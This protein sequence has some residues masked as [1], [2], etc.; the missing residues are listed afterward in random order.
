[1]PT[2]SA[3]ILETKSLRL[4]QH[5]VPVDFTIDGGTVNLFHG[6]SR[7][8]VNLMVRVLGLLE[9]PGSGELYFG[10]TCTSELSDDARSLLR[11][12]RFGFVF[13]DPF[14]L[15]AFSVVEN[16]AMPLLKVFSSDAQEARERTEA[17]LQLAEIPEI[18]QRAA[19][20]LNVGTQ[21][22][23]A[24]ARAIAHRPAVVVVEHPETNLQLEELLVFLELLRH[25]S[26]QLGAA[27]LVS[28]ES[29][30][31]RSMADRLFGMDGNG[32]IKTGTGT[33]PGGTE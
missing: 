32:G 16:V 29:P 33:K 27:V 3:S 25:A 4:E 18:G 31:A 7:E 12:Q 20:S 30:E 8:T 5:S 22:R 17:A 14:L 19:I 13:S 23:V 11:N 21:M 24:L 6:P 1:M 15:P 2:D 10:Q 9:R 26:R 28:S